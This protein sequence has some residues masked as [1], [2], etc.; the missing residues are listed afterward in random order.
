M[1]GLLASDENLV[2]RLPLP[3]AQLY[4]RAQN[5]KTPL[6]RHQAAY[7][8]WEAALK[9][10]GSIAVVEYAALKDHDPDLADRLRNLARPALG[11]WWEFVRRL[12]PVLADS[13]H[14]DL[15]AARDLVLGQARD[16]L[17]RAAGLDALLREVLDGSSGARSTVRLS[18]LFERLVR[19]R[20]RE[21]GHGATGQ[22]PA[23]FYERMGQAMLAGSG[24]I[25]SHLDVLVARR[26]I[27]VDDVRRQPS[28]RWLVERYELSGESAR[29]LESLEV[30]DSE[31][32]RIILPQRVHVES[33]GTLRSLHPLVL[34]EPE[35]SEFLFLSA[36][37]G[38]QRVE[39]LSYSSGRVA[40][41]EDLGGDRCKLLSAVLG[42]AVDGEALSAWAMRSRA[43]D[44]T[45]AP[46]VDVPRRRAIGEF[47]L[48]SKIGRGGMGVVYRAWQP[49]LGRQVALKCVLSG[50][51]AKIEARF[52]REIR[53]LGSVE[54]PNLVKIF[55]SGSDGEQWF[56]AMELIEGADLAS[57]CDRL[58]G[59]TASNVSE[60]GWRHALTSACALAREREEIVSPSPRSP[61]PQEPPASGETSPSRPTGSPPAL[62]RT[63]R[64]HIDRAV[65]VLRQAAEAAHALHEAGVIHRDIKPGNIMLTAAGAHAVLMDL[66]LA[67]LAD[68]TDG[69]LTRTRQFVGTLRYASPEQVLATGFLDRRADV[70]SLGATLWEL[71][72]LRPLFG[73]T[74][75]TPTPELMLK[76][77]SVEPERP[78]RIN[79]R[80]PADLE[81]IVLKCL[82]KDRARRYA[83]ALDLAD[84][85][86]RF[87]RGEPVSAEPPTLKYLLG[88]HIRRHRGRFALAAAVVLLALAG[89]ATALV[90][91]ER[92]RRATEMALFD[93]YTSLGLKA[94]EEGNPAQ[95]L[96]WF[97]GASKRARDDVYRQ[98]ATAARLSSWQG[99]APAPV[100]AFLKPGFQPRQIL[101]DPTGSYLLALGQDHRFVIW[102]IERES[103]MSLP[104]GE[105]P[106]RLAAW[107]PDGKVL[108]L[109]APEGDVDL[110]SFPARGLLR[111][112]APLGVVSTIAFSPD[113]G[114][115]AIGGD[116]LRVADV[117][118]ERAPAEG[119]TDAP[120]VHVVFNR[121]GDRL[122]AA[123]AD[124][125]TSV[126]ATPMSS[127][128]AHALFAPLLNLIPEVQVWVFR[129]GSSDLIR[130]GFVDEDR[131]IAMLTSLSDISLWDSETG[132]LIKTVSFSGALISTAISQDGQH[133][134]GGHEDPT[135][136]AQIWNIH[137]DRPASPPL[138]HPRPVLEAAF[139]A[140][141]A[142]AWT[143]CE[144]GKVRLWSVPSGTLSIP[145]LRGDVDQRLLA[146]ISSPGGVTRACFSPDAR[147]VATAGAS[148]LV[149]IWTVPEERLR[150]RQVQFSIASPAFSP[151]NQY[152]LPIVHQ[153]FSVHETKVY[154][155]ATGQPLSVPLETGGILLGVA[156]CPDERHLV[157]LSST[158][159][160]AAERRAPDFKPEET[161]GTLRFWDW[162]RG[163]EVLDARA[164][165]SEPL[166]A[167]YSPDG[168]T[169]ALLCAGGE[170][171]LLDPKSGAQRTKLDRGKH[172]GRF[173][174]FRD[175]LIQFTPGGRSFITWGLGN[176]VEVWDAASAKLLFPPLEHEGSY[177]LDAVISKDGRIL[178]TAFTGHSVTVWD[179]ETGARA[180][181]SFVHPDEL[182]TVDLTS[183]AR[184]LLT[185]SSDGMARIWDWRSGRL[186]CP[187]LVHRYQ[188]LAARFC[189]DERWIITSSGDT[190]R[191]WEWQTGKQVSPDYHVPGTFETKIRFTADGSEAF[192]CGALSK[193]F[194]LPLHDFGSSPAKSAADSATIQ[195]FGEVISGQRLSGEGALLN[196]SVEEWFE[197]WG[198]L[199]KERPDLTPLDRS[200][201]ALRAWHR[202]RGDACEEGQQCAGVLWHMDRLRALGEEVDPARRWRLE[203]FV[204][205]WR[206]A[207]R[208]EPWRD[209]RAFVSMDTE[210]LK[211]I[212]ASALAS[213][214]V[215]SPAPYLDFA[216]YLPERTSFAVG[217]ALR[218]IE[219]EAPRRVKIFAGSDDAMRVWLNG[220]LVLVDPEHHEAIPDLH[221]AL[222][223]LQQGTNRLLVEVSTSV[224]S[225]ILYLRL[226]E[227]DGTRL[228]LTSDG[229]LERADRRK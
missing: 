138:E 22:R 160:L 8:L 116:R 25:L 166:D 43:E 3:L 221:S 229:R 171:F 18:E 159:T 196:L 132:S 199:R 40:E 30:S 127:T 214:P 140:D 136:Q 77:Q 195:A 129:E 206:F 7:F 148:G 70:Y 24:E 68:D 130:P 84:D 161:P 157:T 61:K 41:R 100:R 156:F 81:A 169:L 119:P 11:H 48:L 19:Y 207:P 93:M 227:E 103:E 2:R 29:R 144:D 97:A 225:W 173:A 187:P 88:K 49:S 106:V 42:Y 176:T 76:V 167:D 63:G 162:R 184:H 95:A 1:G 198:R 122:L 123:C 37:R 192:V 152:G 208:T 28:G 137:A 67:Q 120:V 62:I 66:G 217:W 99:R 59:S 219:C 182:S 218:T 211:A 191:I 201:E 15:R 185:A 210:K 47:E 193:L 65:G 80:V 154:D 39:Y 142:E 20:N 213:M 60:E 98:E 204:R 145:W 82:E 164:T 155:V 5:A 113:G 34:F 83:T 107:S 194:F 27:Y 125:R 102:D 223:D 212:E 149:Q 124:G 64:G 91:I 75:K 35:T 32:S 53:S 128:G 115:L 74:D 135:N 104:G 179:L 215:T 10:L 133:I 4:R 126:F 228:R 170:I 168:Q 36:R 175:G 85:L 165:P 87:E 226:E 153:Y 26:L 12:V 71:L 177:G 134:L 131:K 112:V 143:V 209:A 44:V 72:T 21:L 52:A 197:R 110:V 33:A 101:W 224:G 78:R 178:V 94:H 150:R 55:T 108:A 181:P 151:T 203:E 163:V 202:R 51:D 38:R 58:T 54:H 86:R 117:R 111:K 158:A 16:D 46:P 79:P 14:D 222:V 188:V 69:R 56:Y 9:L 172:P 90:R 141:G 146:T 50:G 147:W 118:T 92:E 183:D 114:L 96:L 17:P 109:A 105:R 220:T 23:D 190:L 216:G 89:A 205:T 13:G 189:P 121:K 31:R 73:A 139:G 186:A 174:R 180:A 6:E 200:P 57:I 45:E